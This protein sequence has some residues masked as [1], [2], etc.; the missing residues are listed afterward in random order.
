MTTADVLVI[1]GGLVGLAVAAGAAARGASVCLIGESRTGEAS[2]AGAGM[3]APGAESG[4]LQGDAVVR[5][6]VAGRDLFPS[7][8]AALRERTGIDVPLDRS[9]ILELALDHEPPSQPAGSEWIDARALRT[10]EPTLA[11]FPGALLHPYDGSVDNVILLQALRR[12]VRTYDTVELVAVRARTLNLS[13]ARPKVLLANEEAVEG[14]CVVLAGGAWVAQLGGLPHVVPV[15]PVRGQMLSLGASGLHHVT[16]GGGG[17]LVPRTGGRTLV[18]A[19]MENVGYDSGT[20]PEARVSLTAIAARLSPTLGAA[21]LLSHWAGLR[22]V[23]PDGLPILGHD[24]AAPGVLYACGH[25]RNGILLAPI[26]GETIGA[27]A[28]GESPS[29]DLAPFSIDRFAEDA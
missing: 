5:F 10:L 13:G 25:G 19:T 4:E 26:T 20:T 9:G 17:Y 3:L 29:F 23:T 7:Y 12:L 18:G 22:P 14:G 21:P 24:G 27:L 1:G 6:A 16:Y 15:R 28:V 2:A 8:L 11:A